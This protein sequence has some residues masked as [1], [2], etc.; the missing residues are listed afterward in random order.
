MY[1]LLTPNIFCEN[2]AKL[3]MFY[4][5][6][7]NP[8]AAISRVLISM[9]GGSVPG[10]SIRN[11]STLERREA[12]GVFAESEAELRLA[13]VWG[14]L[15]GRKDDDDDREQEQNPWQMLTISK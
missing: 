7:F 10:K 4:K 12:S 6:I 15:L 8:H 9:Q 5:I 3:K 1:I 11:V 13:V 14:S 2:K